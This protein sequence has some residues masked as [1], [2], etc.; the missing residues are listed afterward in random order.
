[1]GK[2]RPSVYLP[3][4]TRAQ[5]YDRLF[6]VYLDLHDHFGRRTTTMRRLKAL[7]R[8][9]VARRTSEGAEGETR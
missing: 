7:R 6:E 1:M 2:V 5:A 9:A 3:D 4:E 8:D